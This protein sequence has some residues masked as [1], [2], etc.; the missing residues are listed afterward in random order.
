MC[1]VQEPKKEV[2]KANRPTRLALK[3]NHLVEY[4][5]LDSGAV[6][7]WVL[8]VA[9]NSDLL[10]APK[11]DPLTVH[12]LLDLRVVLKS[13]LLVPPKC[14]RLEGLLLSDLLGVLK[15]DQVAGLHLGHSVE[16]EE[17]R[18]FELA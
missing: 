16:E 14:E 12:L 4:P 17:D 15:Y 10:V 1:P 3:C 13:N 6:L 11:R 2:P 9:I 18:H 8:R 7:E 5:L